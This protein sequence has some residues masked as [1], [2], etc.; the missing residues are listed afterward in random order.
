MSLSFAVTAMVLSGC[1]D[2]CVDLSQQI[3]RCESTQTGQAACLQRLDGRVASRTPTANELEQCNELLDT[4]NCDALA[5][6]DYQAC[7]LSEE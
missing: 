6:G 3:C 5:N 7:G 2:S 4:C 1:D